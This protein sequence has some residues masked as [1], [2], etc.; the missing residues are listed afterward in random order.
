MNVGVVGQEDL[1]EAVVTVMMTGHVE[2]EGKVFQTACSAQLLPEV[3]FARYYCSY[4]S[5]LHASKSKGR[6]ENWLVY[7]SHYLVGGVDYIYSSNY[8]HT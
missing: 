2:V 5:T 8:T 7:L 3:V 4:S 6:G 1:M